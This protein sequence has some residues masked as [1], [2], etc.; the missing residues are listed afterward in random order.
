MSRK[1]V[2][3]K[4]DDGEHGAAQ[5]YKHRLSDPNTNVRARLSFCLSKRVSTSWSIGRRRA[6]VA[7]GTIEVT[8]VFASSSC[9]WEAS[10]KPQAAG[11]ISL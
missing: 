4:C 3:D 10:S 6:N 8:S 7:A 1:G 11:R 5:R 2:R 9:T